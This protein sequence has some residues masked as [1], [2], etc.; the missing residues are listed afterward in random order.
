LT[1]NTVTMPPNNHTVTVNYV[2]ACY[3]LTR[4]FTG[5]GSAPTANP[6]NS[7]GCPAGQY[8]YQQSITM[9]AHPA[10]GYSVSSWAGTTNNASTSLNNT[11]TMPANARTV[12]ANYV[13]NCYTLTQIFTGVGSAPTALP[14]NSSA[15]SL[16]KY[17]VGETIT[18]KA[19]PGPGYH[20]DHWEGANDLYSGI[21]TMPPSA[22]TVTAVY[23]TA[24][25]I[26]EPDDTFDQAKVINPGAPQTRSI[27]PRTDFDWIKFTIDAT[28]A[29]TLEVIGPTPDDTRMW[30]YNSSLVELA[31]SDDEGTDSYSLVRFTCGVN[32]LSPGTY[33]AKI[34]E[35]ANNNEIPSYDTYLTTQTCPLDRDTTGV[36]RP[37]NGLLYLK[38]WNI[39]GF[40]DA[41]LN[42]GVPGD[43]PV[44]GDWDGNGTVT[45]GIYRN[46]TFYLRNSNTIGFAEIVFP[47]GQLGDQPIAGDWD[48]DGDDTIGVF[49]PST[50]QFLLRNSNDAGAADASFFL[51][52]VGDVGVAGDWNGDGLD[53]TGVFRPS[54]GVI[55]LKNTNNTGFADIALN[56]GIPGDQPV[57]G[58]WNNDGIDTI[59]IY[60]NGTFYLR[61]SNTNGFAEIVFGLGNPGDKPLAGNWDALP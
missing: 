41:A 46:G 54:N 16:G 20:L 22:R 35:Y 11:V 9:T 13:A 36:F 28:S 12:T 29:V 49:R 6:A 19:N 37:S 55:F 33:Y 31:F 38:N 53:T 3:T 57:M 43:Y 44:V 23:V 47:F 30:L 59:G 21:L 8:T 17:I 39:T 50:G 32:P 40:A 5:T 58:D 61:N 56:Y 15:C 24:N 60:R 7:T 52:N 27:I 4:T 48:G 1:T 14:T 45:I 26:Y 51:G 2:A 42:Y 34:D 10:A 18:L 25:D